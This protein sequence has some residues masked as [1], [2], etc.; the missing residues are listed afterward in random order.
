MGFF[1][2]F[3][4]QIKTFGALIQKL[5]ISFIWEIKQLIVCLLLEFLYME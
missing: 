5:S 3:L 2:I 4:K 1:S